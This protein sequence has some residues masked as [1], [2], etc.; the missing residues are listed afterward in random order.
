M[1][2]GLSHL[3]ALRKEKLRPVSLML[4]VDIPYKPVKYEYQLRY[5]ELVAIGSV[6]RDDFRPFVDLNVLLYVPKW[7]SLSADCFEKLKE[8][9]AEITLLSPQYGPDIGF[10]WSRQYGMLDMGMIGWL[11]QFYE[12]K[13]RV[14]RTDEET[15]ERIRLEQEAMSHLDLHPSEYKGEQRG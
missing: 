12:A 8:H 10:L 9:A 2:D 3:I 13:G 14:C 7:N 6:A 5:M 15:K 11:E 4:S 1:I